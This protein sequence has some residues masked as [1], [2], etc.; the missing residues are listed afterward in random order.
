M[1]KVLPDL[2]NVQIDELFDKV[3]ALHAKIEVGLLKHIA[4]RNKFLHKI[5]PI[6]PFNIKDKDPAE[7]N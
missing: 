5:L 1:A 7:S 3:E 2:E 6:F 4:K